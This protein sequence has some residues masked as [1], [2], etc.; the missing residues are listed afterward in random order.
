MN[1]EEELSKGIFM[2]STCPKCEQTI[3]PPN[4]ICSKCFGPAKWE[5]GSEF[6]KIIEFSQKNEEYFCLGEFD[7]GVK[8]MGSLSAKSKPEI[9][10]K[11][12]LT[13]AEINN[14]NY[15][16]QMTNAEL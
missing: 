4:E 16:F 15:N 7:K 14:G 6:G 9:G 3:W 10:Q 5:K 2:I 8:I 1:F 11:I 12:R 13:K